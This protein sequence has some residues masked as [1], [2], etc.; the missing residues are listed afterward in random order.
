MSNKQLPLIQFPTYV[1]I[2]TYIY[3]EGE[4]SVKYQ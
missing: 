1:E 4:L 3:I 2:Y